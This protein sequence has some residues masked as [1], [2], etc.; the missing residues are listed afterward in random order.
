M[1]RLWA[2]LDRNWLES[3]IIYQRPKTQKKEEMKIEKNERMIL[4]RKNDK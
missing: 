3:A 1:C 2:L 4:K